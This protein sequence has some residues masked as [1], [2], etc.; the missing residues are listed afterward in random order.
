[1][2]AAISNPQQKIVTGR[3]LRGR[4]IKIVEESDGTYVVVYTRYILGRVFRRKKLSFQNLRDAEMSYEKL[5]IE[6]FKGIF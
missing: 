1:M 4:S 5:G 6:K 3:R 2:V